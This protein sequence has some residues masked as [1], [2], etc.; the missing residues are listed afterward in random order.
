MALASLRTHDAQIANGR[1]GTARA[2]GTTMR[3]A[4]ALAFVLGCSSLGFDMPFDVPNVTVPGNPTAHALAMPYDGA[5]APFALDVDLTQAAKEN[6]LPG[7]ITAVTISTLDFTVKGDGCFD[8]VD[9]VSL[10]IESTKKGTPLAPAVIATGA[11][12]GCVRVLAL[13]PTTVDLKPYIEEGAL[14]RAAGSGVPPAT[15]VTFDGRVVLHA[16]L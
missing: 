15:P 10:T 3:L 14:I 1:G 16:A 12:P 7:A 8:F 2:S 5:S 4:A 9:D 11:S 6:Q 13:T